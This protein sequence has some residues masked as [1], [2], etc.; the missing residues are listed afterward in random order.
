MCNLALKLLAP[1]VITVTALLAPP[2]FAGPLAAHEFIFT[3]TSSSSL[4]VFYDGSPLGVDQPPG[5]PDLWN[6]A[7]PTGFL[8]TVGTP[9]WAEPE[10]SNLVNAVSFGSAITRQ[11]IVQSDFSLSTQLPVNANG[12]RIQ[13]GTDG[14]IPVFATFN[15]NGDAA[16]VPETGTTASLFGLSLAGLAFLRRNILA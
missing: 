7:L 5:F 11:G 3:E 1:L 15:D 4:S 6:F 2:V 12:A 8:S 16:T 9:Q 10:N 14:G 13:V